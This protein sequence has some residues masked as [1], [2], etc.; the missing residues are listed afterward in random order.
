MAREI[1]CPCGHKMQA[2]DDKAL[3]AVVRDHIDEKHPELNYSRE[4]IEGMIRAE[5]RNCGT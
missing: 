5:A 2:P 4:D 3:Y 1:T